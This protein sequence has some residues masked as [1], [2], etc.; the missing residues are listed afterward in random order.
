M[1]AMDKAA[2]TGGFVKAKEG[3]LKGAGGEE[4]PVEVGN[5]DEIML[6]DDDDDE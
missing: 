1:A 5:A 4:T 2:T 6:D 3:G